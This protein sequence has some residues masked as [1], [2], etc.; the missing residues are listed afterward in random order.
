MEILTDKRGGWRGGLE[1]I[2]RKNVERPRKLQFALSGQVKG[3]GSII[4]DKMAGHRGPRLACF[5]DWPEAT[6]P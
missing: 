1:E 6:M 4:G 2:V 5:L 3:G